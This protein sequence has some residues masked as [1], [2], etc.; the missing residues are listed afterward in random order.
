MFTCWWLQAVGLHRWEEGSSVSAVRVL[1]S[2]VEF[3][4]QGQI[5][6]AKYYMHV[7]VIYSDLGAVPILRVDVMISDPSHTGTAKAGM[8][9]D[10]LCVA[11]DRT[12]THIYEYIYLFERERD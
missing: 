5:C 4:G 1:S 12:F 8:R 10:I 9:S 7:F 3:K 11:S 6:H 2:T